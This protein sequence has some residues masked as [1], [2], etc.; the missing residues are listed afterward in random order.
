MFTLFTAAAAIAAAPAAPGTMCKTALSVAPAGF[1]CVEAPLGVALAPDQERAEQ[2]AI[3]AEAGEVRFKTHFG[4]DVPRYAVVDYDGKS[5]IGDFQRSLNKTGFRRTLPWLSREAYAEAIRGATRQM[6]DAMA[7]AAN[8][9]PAE[10]DE[11][12][13]KEMAT[14]E[15][16]LSPYEMEMF[17]GYVVPHEI[18]HG[19]YTQTYWPGFVMDKMGHYG[20]PSP[21]W[22]YET[23]SILM[24]SGDSADGRRH[25]F[26]ETY[27]G[28]DKRAEAAELLNLR[29]FLGRDH[30]EK[31]ANQS[32]QQQASDGDG[33]TIT[34]VQPK[35]GMS[36]ARYYEQGRMFADFLIDRTGDRAIFGSIG[37]AFGQGKSMDQWLAA[38]GAA[39]GL[40]GSVEGL[41]QQWREW[42]RARFGPPAQVEQ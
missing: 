6:V 38:N 11:L 5:K 25:Y 22:L 7:A 13:A 10:K 9:T 21:D 20:S 16:G 23:A 2:L 29:E 37:E 41:E 36:G 15:K 30:P 32:T 26:R 14:A 42:L 4:R 19:W 12:L 18:G 40:A 33:P 17:E 31:E 1:H 8:M 3:Y 35:E 39:N 24:E 28:R 27:W 34:V